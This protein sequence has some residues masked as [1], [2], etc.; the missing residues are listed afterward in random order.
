MCDILI[1]ERTK[2]IV[3]LGNSGNIDGAP[4]CLAIFYAIALVTCMGMTWT[5]VWFILMPFGITHFGVLDWLF[6]G[7]MF[8]FL[9][10][11]LPIICKIQEDNKNLQK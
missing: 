4:T 6:K 3:F 2:M 8:C 1:S 9:I 5:F 7:L 10:F 11:G